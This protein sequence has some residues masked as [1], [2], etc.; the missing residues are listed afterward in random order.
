MKRYRFLIAILAVTLTLTLPG[1]DLLDPDEE[2]PN[3]LSGDPYIDNA[4]VGAEYD[5]NL[6]FDDYY[7]GLEGITDDVKIIKNDGIVTFDAKFTVDTTWLRTMDTIMGTTILPRQ[8]K[9]DLIYDYAERYGATIDTTDP[10]A[11]TLTIQPKFKITDQGIQEFMNSKGDETR[12]FTIIKYNMNVGDS[13]Q[14][15][16][17]DGTMLTRKVTYHSTT[18]DYEVGFMRIKVFKV[19]ETGEDPMVESVTYVANHKFGLVAAEYKF[20]SGKTIKA[21]IWPPNL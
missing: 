12:P 10:G 13:W 17:D 6:R 4:K 15:R 21:G 2:G 11:I 14:F 5:V 18:D 9:I 8:T 19:V 20:K 7:P 3:D 1:C 16:R